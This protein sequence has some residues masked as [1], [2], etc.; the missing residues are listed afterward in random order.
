M[1]SAGNV[2]RL[3]E[4]LADKFGERELRPQRFHAI[5]GDGTGAV[6]VPGKPNYVYIR[7]VGRGLIEECLNNKAAVRD[8]LPVIAGYSHES[9][10]IL[11]ILEVDWPSFSAPGDYSYVQHHHEAHELHNTSGGDDVVWVQSQQLMPL[12][13]YPTDPATLFVNV[14]GGWYPWVSGWHY[15]ESTLSITFAAHVPAL[16]AEARYVLVSIDGATEALQY[17]AGA[18]FP[19]FLPPADAEDMVPAPPAGSIPIGAVYLVFGATAI[20]WDELFDMR[21]FSQPVGGSVMPG[22]HDHTAIAEGGVLVQPVIALM[23]CWIGA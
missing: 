7:R 14:F 17:T 21:L 8:G 1:S 15:F 13:V 10:E 4:N 3:R 20:G 2:L 19:I 9:P 16:P 11:Q 12:L 6:S 5:M 22:V 23:F 18:T